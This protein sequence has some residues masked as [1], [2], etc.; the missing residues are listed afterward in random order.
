MGLPAL[1]VEFNNLPRPQKPPFDRVDN[2][3]SLVLQTTDKPP[4]KALEERLRAA[5]VREEPRVVLDENMEHAC[6]EHNEKF[7]KARFCLRI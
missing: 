3:C 5:G 4:S 6:N 1:V 2:L 7:L